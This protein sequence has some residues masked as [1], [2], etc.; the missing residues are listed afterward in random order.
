VRIVSPRGKILAHP[1]NKG[2]SQL[3]AE[4]SR[5]QGDELEPFAVANALVDIEIDC[6][7][8]LLHDS[9]SDLTQILKANSSMH[10]R[11]ASRLAVVFGIR[12][13]V[14]SPYPL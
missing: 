14:L 4:W 7:H 12:P 6:R 5:L 1:F 9:C 2:Q 3:K 10:D 8:S 13:R 11:S